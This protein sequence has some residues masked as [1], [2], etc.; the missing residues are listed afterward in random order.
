MTSSLSFLFVLPS[1]FVKILSLENRN[2]LLQDFLVMQRRFRSLPLH[3]FPFTRLTPRPRRFQLLTPADL[4]AES[5]KGLTNG[6]AEIVSHSNACHTRSQN[7]SCS[8]ESRKRHARHNR[9]S[10][11]LPLVLSRI[12]HIA[13]PEALPELLKVR[14][15]NV[16]VL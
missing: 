16:A 11:L 3:R 15:G 6:E 12:R 13:F 9:D 4:H 7:C 5:A 2:R 1:G 10:R 8:L 14:K